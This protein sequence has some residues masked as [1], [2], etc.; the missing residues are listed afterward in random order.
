[1]AVPQKNEVISLINQINIRLNKALINKI[2][3]NKKHLEEIKKHYIFTNPISIYQAKEMSFDAILERLKYSLTNLI[4]IKEKNYQKVT[5]SIVLQNPEILFDK[6][7]NKYQ[8]VAS[9]IVL[10]NPEILFDKK[11]NKY[12]NILS[13]LEAL[14]PLKTLQRGYSITKKDDKVI[15]SIKNIK[16]GDNIKIEFNDGDIDAKVI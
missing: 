3:I 1:M 14:S 13:K 6:K 9:S 11:K 8:K 10:Q 2:N 12:I 5:S 16:K 4:H 15:T 7:K